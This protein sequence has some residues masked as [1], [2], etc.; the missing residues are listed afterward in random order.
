MTDPFNEKHL[1]TGVLDVAN[2]I[3]FSVDIPSIGWYDA[4]FKAGECIG[5]YNG[6]RVF[7]CN[8]VE[9]FPEIAG[10]EKETIYVYIEEDNYEKASEFQA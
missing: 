3:I 7:S 4:I 2:G 1:Y 9:H 5:K 6:I 8:Q 10:N